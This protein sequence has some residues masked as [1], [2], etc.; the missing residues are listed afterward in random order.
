MKRKYFSYPFLFWLALFI[1]LPTLLIV[2]YAVTVDKSGIT[3]VSFENFAKPFD[4]TYLNVFWNSIWMAV[5]CTAICLILGYPVAYILAKSKTRSNVVMMLI[6]MPMWMNFLLRTYA[7]MAILDTNGLINSVFKLFGASPANMLY[8]PFAI[9]LGMVYNFFPFMILPIYTVL[10]KIPHAYLE[11]AEDLGANF[12]KVLTKVIFP[13]SMEGVVSGIIMV[14]MPAITTFAISR[15]LG[16]SQI[17]LLGDLIENQFM[18]VRDWHFG[19][20]LSFL[21]LV[22]MVITM[23]FTNVKDMDEGGKLW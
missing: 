4:P 14:F 18:L 16:G 13:L 9:I 3:M 10:H 6:M 21:L 19:S 17:M 20:T 22:L 15:L 7:W 23:F 8:T 11:A 2:Y 1:V 12:R 5:V